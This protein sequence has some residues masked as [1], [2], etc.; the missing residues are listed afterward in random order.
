MGYLS[1]FSFSL[2]SGPEEDYTSMLK[3]IDQLIGGSGDESFEAKWYNCER[4]MNEIAKKYPH[5]VVQMDVDGE[6]SDDLWRM[7]ICNGKTEIYSVALPEFQNIEYRFLTNKSPF[8]WDLKNRLKIPGGLIYYDEFENTTFIEMGKVVK[9]GISGNIKSEIVQQIADMVE[10]HIKDN[11]I[12][13][14]LVAWACKHPD[15]SP[16]SCR[17]G[18]EDT[19]LHFEYDTRS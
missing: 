13:F 4:D 8:T 18:D 9:V 17:L 15:L 19:K 14:N 7:F 10:N 5:I 3:D 12:I 6:D 2:L 11:M 1:L 16:A